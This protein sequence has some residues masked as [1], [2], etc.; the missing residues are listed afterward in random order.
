M[1]AAAKGSVGGSQLYTKDEAT[2]AQRTWVFHL[3]KTADQ[4]DATGLTPVVTISKAA[5]PDPPALTQVATISRAGGAFAAA[6]GVVTELANG[7]YK[8]VWA[9]TDLDT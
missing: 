4:A 6:D 8:M 3:C 7:F 2:A 5:Q 1:T 9:A